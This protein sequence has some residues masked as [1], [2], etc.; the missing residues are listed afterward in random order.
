M[1]RVSA[2]VITK[3]EARNVERCLASLAPVADEILVVD[4]YSSDGTAALC[5]S[6]GARVVQQGWLGFG[7]QKNVGNGLAAHEW[8][9]SLDADEALDPPLQRAIAEAKAAGLRGVYEVSRLNWYYGRFVRHGLEYPDR[10]IRLFPRSRA[11]W[12]ESLVHEGLRLAEPLPVT[13]LDGHLLHY[14]YARVEE[15]VAKANR[16]TSLAAED[17]HR[18]GVRPSVARM[19]LSPLAVLV[20]SYL[21]RRGFLDGLHGLVIAA[22]HAS[23]AFQK[24]AKLWDLHRAARAQPPPAAAG[25]TPSPRDDAVAR[26]D[27]SPRP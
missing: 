14:T 23:A 22:L 11:S 3:N 21:L 5:A 19:L 6:L 12:D 1:D 10:K 25:P 18:R 2:V 16:Y 24:H 9:L 27:A 20:K 8:I 17:A 26:R 4:E 7:P 15:H 13:R